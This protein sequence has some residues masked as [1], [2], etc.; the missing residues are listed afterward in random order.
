MARNQTHYFG[1]AVGLPG[2]AGFL[3][4]RIA[5][6]TQITYPDNA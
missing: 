5:R 3:D 4:E 1:V 6:V 2:F